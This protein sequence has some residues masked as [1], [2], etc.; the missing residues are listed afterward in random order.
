VYKRQIY[1][2]VPLGT[3]AEVTLNAKLQI[4]KD[5]IIENKFIAY[6]ESHVRIDFKKETE[7]SSAINI[8]SH[9]ENFFNFVFSLPHSTHM[10][11]SSNQKS[12]KNDLTLYILSP[13]R[14]KEYRRDEKSDKQNMLFSW[15]QLSNINDVFVQWLLQYERIHEVA[16]TIVLLKSTRVSEEMRFTSIINALEAVHRRYFDH[17]KESDKHYES[18]MTTILSQI[19]DDENKTLVKQR[20]EYGNEISLRKRLKEVYAAGETFGIEK[21]TKNL[22]D[23]IIE[24]RNYYTHGDES[25]K[26]KILNS[27]DLFLA[28]SLLGRYLKLLLLQILGVKDDE[29][30]IIV[31]KSSQFQPYYRDE[32]SSNINNFF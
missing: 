5:G 11:T 28:N 30:K 4:D 16:D 23:K 3:F 13:S 17:K 29:L 12:G 32:P 9:V 18:R 24:T 19:A 26:S 22:T 20:L 6:P 7:I 15:E 25:K 27:N 8:F 31:D 2:K 14:S 1:H 21:P 10:F